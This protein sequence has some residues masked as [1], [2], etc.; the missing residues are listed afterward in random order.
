M[1]SNFNYSSETS[2]K[3]IDYLMEK[4]F[5][6]QADADALKEKG[7]KQKISPLGVFLEESVDLREKAA[8]LIAHLSGKPYFVRTDTLTVQTHEVLDQDILARCGSCLAFDGMQTQ[9]LCLD[10]FHEEFNKLLKHPDL[11]A[12]PVSVISQETHLYIVSH[13]ATLSRTRPIVLA[14]PRGKVSV[15]GENEAEAEN[16]NTYVYDMLKKCVQIGASDIHIDLAIDSKNAPGFRMR[17]RVDGK[18][19]DAGLS[20]DIMLYRGIVNK[21]KLDAG[22]KIDERRLPQDGRISFELDGIVHNFRLSFM[23]NTIRNA[24]EEKIVLRQM[25]DVKKCDLYGLDIL[26]YDLRFF[27][28]AIQYPHGFVCV[29]GPTGSGKTT[30]LYALLQQIDRESKNVIT[31]EDPIE[32]EIPSVNQSQMFHRIGYDFAMGLRVILRQDPDIVM[33]GEMR[34]EETALKAF[35]ASNTGHLV[36]STLHTNTAASS[37]TRLLQMNVPY[38]FISSSL[39]FIVAQRLVRRVCTACRRSHPDQK[40]VMEKIRATFQDASADVKALYKA[41]LPSATLFASTPNGKTCENCHGVGYRGRIAILEVMKVNDEI[42]KIINFDHGN[43]DKIQ[44]A[45]LQGGMLSIQQY[46]YLQVMKGLTTFEEVNNAV[47]MS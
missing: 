21:L 33:V 16:A 20:T 28:E 25:A 9:I 14:K 24:Q 4:K 3:V 32:A 47:L 31:L 36:F 5:L 41:A 45:A 38:Y 15:V 35:E 22:L 12:V 44:Q 7:K 18:C 30:L 11:R 6:T 10:P 39:K 19:H 46:G 37:I 13:Y 1:K 27:E 23:P 34:D 43:E 8:Q 26:P 42:R 40:E 2:L 29:T 17:F